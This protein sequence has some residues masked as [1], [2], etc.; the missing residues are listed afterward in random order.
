MKLMVKKSDREETSEVVPGLCIAV[1]RT[2]CSVLLLTLQT[3]V[4]S[5]E[6]VQYEAPLNVSD[7]AVLIV[8]NVMPF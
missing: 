8:F 5:T 1:Y 2:M 6:H 7:E 4:P 3:P